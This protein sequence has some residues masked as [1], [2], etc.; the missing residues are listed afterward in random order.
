MTQPPTGATR[1]EAPPPDLREASTG[2]L[3]DDLTDQSTRLVRHGG[4]LAQA[5]VTQAEVTRKA[6]P[7]L[8]TGTLAGAQAGIATVMQGISR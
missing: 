5:E 3:I 8:P 6:K 1:A 7:P 2:R 4:R